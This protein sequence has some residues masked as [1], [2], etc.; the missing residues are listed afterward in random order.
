ML[1]VVLLMRSKTENEQLK[2]VF[3]QEM[4][5]KCKSYRIF[6]FSILDLHQDVIISFGAQLFKFQRRGTMD[7]PT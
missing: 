7:G 4:F 5:S 1:S 3:T 2:K 6:S